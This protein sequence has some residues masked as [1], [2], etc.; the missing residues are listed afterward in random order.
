LL[1]VVVVEGGWAVT[2]GDERD[3]ALR[4]AIGFWISRDEHREYSDACFS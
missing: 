4:T 3:D 2:K 1:I